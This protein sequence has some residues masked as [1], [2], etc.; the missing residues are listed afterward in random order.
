MEH[1]NVSSMVG[2]KPLKQKK[3]IISLNAS[4]NLVN[5]RGGLIRA[6]VD[7]GY[8][9]VAVA[10]E[11]E[12]SPRLTAF[13]CRYVALPMENGG[14]NLFGDFLLGW[15]FFRMFM[16]ERPDVYLGYTV[17]PNVY[18]SMAAHLL[19]I[20]VV[21]NIAGLGA[22]FIKGG[23]LAKLVRGLYR[24]ALGRSAK[25]FFQ[26]NDDRQLFISGKLVHPDVTDLLPGSGID[27]S[28]FSVLPM[29]SVPLDGRVKKFRFLL[30][31]RMLWDKGVGEYVEAAKL[32]KDR[33]P[34]AECCLLGFVDVPNPAAISRT[35]MEA[36]VTE[37]YINY[38]GVSDDV[39]VE[40]ATADCIVL[41]SYRE[42]TPRTL[43][44]A[45]AMG[46]PIITTNA[47]GC[48]E[49]VNDGSNGFLCEVASAKDLAEKMDR[50]LALEGSQRTEMGLLGRKKMELEFD[51]KL[52]ISKYLHA[53]ENILVK[54]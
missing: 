28:K 51:E 37:G 10:P 7:A 33:W 29:P 35:Q 48:R 18:G 14:T 23:M 24:L 30:I 38:L 45:A 16:R 8:E 2:E 53:I 27:L 31:A 39:R 17:K 11:D 4:W 22:V 1:I 54:K 32:I 46:R 26:N 41:P 43:L 19:G 49:V 25:V 52:V 21:N 20:P 3:I 12:Y 44:E 13:G 6:L 36:W 15:R 9:V 34:D 5:F 50:M 47:V 40:I 42:G